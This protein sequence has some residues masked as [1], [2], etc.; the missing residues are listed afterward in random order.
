MK[1][2]FVIATVFDEK[3]GKQVKT[4]QGEFQDLMCAYLFA[5]AYKEEFHSEA[6]VLS[7]D[8]LLNK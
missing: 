6:E 2:Y 8:E 3:Q 1:R 7:E 5:K 4:V